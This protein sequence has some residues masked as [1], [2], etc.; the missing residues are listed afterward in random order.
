MTRSSPRKFASAKSRQT[1]GWTVLEFGHLETSDTRH[2]I[3]HSIETGVPQAEPTLR[4]AYRSLSLRDRHFL[5]QRRPSTN[6]WASWFRRL[7]ILRHKDK[8]QCQF[9]SAPA[10]PRSVVNSNLAR[11]P[12]R[13]NPSFN[14]TCY[15]GRRKAGLQHSVHCRK[16]ALRHPPQPAG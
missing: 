3:K 6:V 16:P 4:Y 5:R 14:R 8:N 12:E 2:K 7:A 15:G 10:Q 9:M 1:R 11:F 13:S